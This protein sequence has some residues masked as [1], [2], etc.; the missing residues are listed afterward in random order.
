MN[1]FDA[2]P[3]ALC[4]FAHVDWA[5]G[6]GKCHAAI[7]CTLCHTHQR[8]QLPNERKFDVIK[9]NYYEKSLFIAFD[10]SKALSPH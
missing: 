9:I 1:C 10:E 3:T 8:V 2:L 5:M 7:K 4:H 6:N